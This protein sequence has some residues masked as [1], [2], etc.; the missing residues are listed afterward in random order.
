MTTKSNFDV[1]SV[2]FFIYKFSHVVIIIKNQQ[3]PVSTVLFQVQS[4]FKNKGFVQK[5]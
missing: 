2:I 5:S 1:L 3:L 4:I